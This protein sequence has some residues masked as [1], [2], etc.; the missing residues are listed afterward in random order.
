[1]TA[2]NNTWKSSIFVLLLV[3]LQWFGTCTQ[4]LLLDSSRIIARVLPSQQTKWRLHVASNS[5]SPDETRRQ[6]VK[7]QLL[8][9]VSSTPANA[10]T[11]TRTTQDILQVVRELEQLCPTPEPEVVPKLGGNWELLWTTQDQSSD[12]WGMGPFRTWIK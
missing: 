2:N 12:E 4:A 8:S 10:P 9:L 7:D 3:V 1:M 11:S 5:V 6:M